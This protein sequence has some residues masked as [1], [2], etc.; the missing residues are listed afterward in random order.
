MALQTASDIEADIEATG[1]ELVVLGSEQTYGHL[2]FVDRVVMEGEVPVK[3]RYRGVRIATGKLTLSNTSRGAT[4]TVAGTSYTIRDF[5][6]DD[7][8]ETGGDG[9]V[10]SIQLSD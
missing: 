9:L 4:I 10:T 2:G 8:F 6:A 1:G 5:W 7:D 3:A